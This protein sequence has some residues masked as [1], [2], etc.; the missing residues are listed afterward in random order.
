MERRFE[1]ERKSHRQ[2]GRWIPATVGNQRGEDRPATRGASVYSDL[3]ALTTSFFFS[4]FLEN[5]SVAGMWKHFARFGVV[6]DIFI[7]KKKTKDGKEFD[8][9]RFRD[10]QNKDQLEKDV[11]GVYIGPNRLSFNLARFGRNNPNGTS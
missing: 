5:W 9:V 7:P 6:V 3:E 1:R 11:R 2:H 10:V 4:N 8:F